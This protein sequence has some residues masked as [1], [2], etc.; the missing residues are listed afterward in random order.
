MKSKSNVL[1][2]RI[3]VN[4]PVVFKPLDECRIRLLWLDGGRVEWH[5][6][7]S[8]EDI[9]LKLAQQKN[10][11]AYCIASRL[12]Q[13]DGTIAGLL[14]ACRAQEFHLD[15]KIED[16]RWVVRRDQVGF[17]HDDVSP[18]TRNMLQSIKD[19]WTAF[20]LDYDYGRKA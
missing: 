11:D 2:D 9:F 13:G 6:A 15:A 5:A 7:E 10:W 17:L 19:A 18:E 12:P 1:L 3:A 8:M 4:W 14:F 20:I 16:G